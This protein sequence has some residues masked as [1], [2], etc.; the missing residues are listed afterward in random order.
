MKRA[1]VTGASGFV[2]ANLVRRLL[3]DGDEVHV[4]LRSEQNFWRLDEIQDDLRTHF[5][6]LRDSDQLR[7]LVGEVKPEWIFH[8]AA[9]G[10][11]SWQTDLPAMI[12][13]NIVG[14]I[15]LINACLTTSFEV[16]VNAGS[17]SEYGFKDHAPPETEFLEP[18]SHYAITKASATLFC[19]SIARARNVTQFSSGRGGSP[20]PPGRLRSI[21]PTSHMNNVRIPTLR[22][23]S[24]YG[25]YE[26]P[27]RLIPALIVHGSHGQLPKLAN[28]EVARDYVYIDD[29]TEAFV[30][31][32]K[33]QTSDPGAVF[34][35][36][37]GT[38]RSLRDVVAIARRLMDISID[39]LWGSMPNRHWDTEVW[40]ADNTKIRQELQWQPRFRLEEGF[41][42]TVEWFRQ[43]PGLFEFYEQQLA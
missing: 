11:Y 35:V 2:G 20:E 19:R 25:P 38:Q 16:L 36:G 42:K 33:L 43:N 26:E 31:A 5:A 34:N 24:V 21:A 29:V 12:E 13:T 27:R 18:N 41:R 32:A 23:Y 39:P 22:L 3:R 6:D 17:S 10:A 8:L 9:Y 30:S 7:R 4:L 40:V 14:T 15:N 37:T 1:F 28:P